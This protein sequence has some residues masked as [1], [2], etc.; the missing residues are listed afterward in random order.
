MD[1]KIE[2]VDKVEQIDSLKRVDNPAKIEVKPKIKVIKRKIS[3]KISFENEKEIAMEFAGKIHQKFDRLVKSTILFGSQAKNTA[4]S[5]SD[6][7]IVVIIDDSS[8]NW[9]L[10]LIAWYREELS[11]LITNYQYSKELHINT[12]RLT[13]WWNDLMYG[14]PVVLNILRYG[15]P[16]ID[17]GGMF[18][19]LK[20]LLQRGKIR[21]THEAVYA[22]LQRAPSHLARSRSAKLGSIEGIYW[23]IVDS[24]QAALIMAGKLPP[25][26]EHIP[27]FLRD[28][29]TSTGLLKSKYVDWAKEIFALHKNITHGSI[30]DIKGEDIDEWQSRANEFLKIMTDIIDNLIETKK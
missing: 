26:P 21:S 24:A 23:T 29:F 1:D 14:D 17:S 3:K 30:S 10:E 19:P 18:I 4:D 5:S 22:A 11:K 6:I 12:V 27:G 7:D 9:D 8:F 16:L 2:N 25:S 13:T 28:T 15:E 20:V